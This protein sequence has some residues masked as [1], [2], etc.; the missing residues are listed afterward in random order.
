[1]RKA[2]S[3]NIIVHYPTTE[4]GRRELQRRVAEVHADAILNYVQK[5]NCQHW[6]KINLLDAIKE[7][8]RKEIKIQKE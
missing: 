4:A 1:M 5:L 8:V 3:I 7:D 6:Q 2:A